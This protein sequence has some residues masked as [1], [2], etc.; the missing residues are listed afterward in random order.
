MGLIKKIPVVDNKKRDTDIINKSKNLITVGATVK[1]G[2]NVLDTINTLSA[3]VNT[4]L[5]KYKDKYKV[6]R[7]EA[8]IKDYFNLIQSNGTAALDTETSGLNPMLDD[9]AGICLY[10]PGE[11]AVY[12]PY[13]H[14]SYITGSRVAN[15]PTKEFLYECFSSWNIV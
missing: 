8:E 1:G 10:T 7:T 9:L 14:I 12:I 3:Y 15:Q 4:K 11:K 5:G 6:L 13:G 2:K